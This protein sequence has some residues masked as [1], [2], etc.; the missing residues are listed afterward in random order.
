MTI[1]SQ[2]RALASFRIA[3]AGKSLNTWTDLHVILSLVASAPALAR[4]VSA[5]LFT[6]SS[7]SVSTGG[8]D[9]G[10][11]WVRGRNKRD[12]GGEGL[13]QLKAGGDGLCRQF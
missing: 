11:R 8:R 2:S 10:T 4:T 3:S 9:T 12:L 5:A 1:T 6:A 13:R 7:S